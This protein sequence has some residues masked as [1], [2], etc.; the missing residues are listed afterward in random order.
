[1][2]QAKIISIGEMVST[3]T[4]NILILFGKKATPVLKDYSVIQE[5]IKGEANIRPQME[6]K[7]G[8]QVYHV[9]KVGNAVAH[10]MHELDHVNI[11]FNPIEED[12]MIS[13]MIYVKPYVFPKLVEGMIITYEE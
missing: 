7:F 10:N 5:F 3:T 6:L 8:D 2:A 13:S 4:E 1:M 9:E 12:K 11:S